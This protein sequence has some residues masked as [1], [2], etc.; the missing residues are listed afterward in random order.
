VT[1]LRTIDYKVPKTVDLE[2]EWRTA[3]LRA[4][5]QTIRYRELAKALAAKLE[6]GAM[7]S[8]ERGVAAGFDAAMA[9]QGHA[10]EARRLEPQRRTV[11]RDETGRI[12]AIVG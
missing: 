4:E 10:E 6:R 2:E 5:A 11:E 7:R 9:A 3:A 12:V 8:Y 1:T